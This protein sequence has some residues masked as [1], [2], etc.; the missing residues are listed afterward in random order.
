MEKKTGYL[1]IRIVAVLSCAVYAGSLFLAPPAPFTG[2]PEAITIG[3]PPDELSTLIWVAEERGFF[4]KNGL[5]VTVKTFDTG[6]SSVNGLL[7]GQSH[8]ATISGY[9]YVSKVF[10]GENLTARGSITITGKGNPEGCPVRDY[11]AGREMKEMQE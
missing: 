3:T 1:L 2:S 4:A 10:A 5:N 6:I 11:R 7:G 9:V 8:L